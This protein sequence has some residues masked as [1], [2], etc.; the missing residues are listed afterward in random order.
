MIDKYYLKVD[1]E[2]TLLEVLA[3]A[4]IRTQTK[5]AP[6]IIPIVTDTTGA[7]RISKSECFIDTPIGNDIFRAILPIRTILSKTYAILIHLG[8]A[9]D[10]GTLRLIEKAESKNDKDVD[11]FKRKLSNF[12]K[13]YR[14]RIKNFEVVFEKLIEFGVSILK[15]IAELEVLKTY[16]NEI[17]DR[18]IKENENSKY[19]L[20]DC[21]IHPDFIKRRLET[22][23]L[24]SIRFIILSIQ[25]GYSA[26]V[27]KDMYEVFEIDSNNSIASRIPELG[28]RAT[29]EY[30]KTAN[31]LV[32]YTIENAIEIVRAF[33]KEESTYNIL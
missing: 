29:F 13:C 25:N 30:K 24:T 33:E 27:N 11:F 21:F 5:N 26:V 22:L 14:T 31:S 6:Q 1:S 10:Y 17:I 16:S 8:I 19:I 28:V 4:L 7:L 23:G 9:L 18:A 32:T 2:P 12:Y 3:A 15:E 20:I